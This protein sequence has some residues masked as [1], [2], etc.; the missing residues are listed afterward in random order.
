MV[1][2]I[3][4]QLKLFNDWKT[5]FV[6]HLSYNKESSRLYFNQLV[7]DISFIAVGKKVTQLPFKIFKNSSLSTN[8]IFYR[9]FIITH[10]IQI[11]IISINEFILNNIQL[12]MKFKKKH[13]FKLLNIVSIFHNFMKHFLLWIIEMEKFFFNNL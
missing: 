3:K 9:V 1:I 4:N 10:F 13:P 11:F 6:L 2:L 5:N 12:K 8:K 7:S